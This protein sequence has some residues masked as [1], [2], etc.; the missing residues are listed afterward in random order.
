MYTSWIKRVKP[1]AEKNAKIESDDILVFEAFNKIESYYDSYQ[2]LKTWA[3]TFYEKDTCNEIGD[4]L[5][6]S[7]IK[8]CALLMLWTTIP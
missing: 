8:I 3:H 1:E 4:K 5:Y 7:K 6:S 2:F